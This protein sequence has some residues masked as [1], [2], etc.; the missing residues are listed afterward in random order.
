MDVKLVRKKLVVTLPSSLGPQLNL[1]QP[2]KTSSFTRKVYKNMYNH[3]EQI[4]YEKFNGALQ[5]SI[6]IITRCVV[7]T[8]SGF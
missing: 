8:E 7:T 4:I 2:H 3:G 5:N 6:Y 1:I